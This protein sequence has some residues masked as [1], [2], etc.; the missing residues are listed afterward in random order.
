MQVAGFD[1]GFDII[2]EELYIKKITQFLPSLNKTVVRDSFVAVP[3]V[4]TETYNQVFSLFAR[5]KT[6]NS[7]GRR[8]S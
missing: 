7:G 1:E 5:S 8:G 3:A 6:S 2:T 4:R